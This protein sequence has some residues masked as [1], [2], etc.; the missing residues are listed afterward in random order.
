MMRRKEKRKKLERE[1]EGFW[2]SEKVKET[3]LEG[4]KRRKE[5]R[6]NHEWALEKTKKVKESWKSERTKLQEKESS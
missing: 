3:W 2:N 4:K 1:N 5:E 6:K